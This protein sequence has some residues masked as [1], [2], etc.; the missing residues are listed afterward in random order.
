MSKWQPKTFKDDG[1]KDM[2]CINCGRYLNFDSKL[3]DQKLILKKCKDCGTSNPIF[4][5][6]KIKI[7]GKQVILFRDSAYNRNPLQSTFTA[8]YTE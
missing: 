6:R 3:S 7:Q 5:P 1:C 8:D 2:H 4:P